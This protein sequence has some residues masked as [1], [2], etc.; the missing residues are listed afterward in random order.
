MT[1]MHM[2][3]TPAMLMATID[4]DELEVEDATLFLLV[5]AHDAVLRRVPSG[6]R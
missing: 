4:V 2:L 1:S 5:H 3:I 6:G